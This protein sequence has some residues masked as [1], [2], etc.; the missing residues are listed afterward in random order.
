MEAAVRTGEQ[1]QRQRDSNNLERIRQHLEKIE[2]EAV[3]APPPSFGMGFQ[4]QPGFM[5]SFL[6]QV[7]R[8]A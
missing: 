8:G 3:A 1:Q 4:R 2:E 7:T 5:A 6:N